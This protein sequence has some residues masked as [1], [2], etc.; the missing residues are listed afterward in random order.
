M[1]LA[2][3]QGRHLL[4]QAE[5]DGELDVAA[6]AALT[7]HLQT[8]PSCA[9]LRR[10]LLNLR[11]QLRGEITPEQA[12]DA[13]RQFL[14]SRLKPKP[15]PW[16]RPAYAMAGGLAIAAILLLILPRATP[17]PLLDQAVALHIRALQPGHLLDVATSNQHVVKPWFDGR[18]DFAPP[19]V[20]L[21]QQGFPLLG[22]RLDYLGRRPAAVLVYGRDRHMI[23]LFVVPKTGGSLA[24]TMTLDG[25]NTLA[26]TKGDMTLIAVSDVTTAD[27]RGFQAAWNAAR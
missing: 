21:A 5:L 8:C 15:R 23:D 10:D 26:W 7:A 19:V 20:D 25:Y 22:G 6:T 27:L 17:D 2:D 9:A 3:C 11:V 4:I 12:P 18:I 1:T 14:M 24:G 13:L 16:R